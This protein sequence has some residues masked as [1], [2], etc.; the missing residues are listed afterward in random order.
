MEIE[1]SH[2]DPAISCRINARAGGVM[3]GDV[4]GTAWDG[5]SASLTSKG[6]Q[7]KLVPADLQISI[8]STCV[9]FYQSELDAWNA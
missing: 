8:P 4:D 2:P 6:R 5:S 7:R 1:S 9:Y 3:V